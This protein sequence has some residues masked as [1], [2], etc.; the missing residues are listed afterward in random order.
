M[1]QNSVQSQLSIIDFLLFHERRRYYI[2]IEF[3]F[4]LQ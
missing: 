2:I 1:I 3:N 4:Q